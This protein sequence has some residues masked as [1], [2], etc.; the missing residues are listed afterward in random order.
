MIYVSFNILSILFYNNKYFISHCI[1]LAIT[2]LLG[3]PIFVGP[4]PPSIPKLEPTDGRPNWMPNRLPHRK[5][6]FYFSLI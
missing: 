1:T 4:M 3:E 5:I 2:Q 6:L